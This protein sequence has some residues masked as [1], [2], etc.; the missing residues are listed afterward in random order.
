MSRDFL[1]HREKKKKEP[2]NPFEKQFACGEE[3]RTNAHAVRDVDC[4][5]CASPFVSFGVSSVQN[6]GFRC[7]RAKRGDGIPRKACSFRRL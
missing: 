3:H 4:L 1:F 7:S 5:S 2:S 6:G